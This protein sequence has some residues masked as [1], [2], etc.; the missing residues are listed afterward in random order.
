MNRRTFMSIAAGALI[1]LS[2]TA[3]AQAATSWHYLGTRKVNP[4]VDQDR[5]H[6]GAVRGKFR[7]IRLTVNGNGLYVYNLRVIY[8]NGAIDNIPVRFHFA[9][10]TWSR[11]ID[12]RGNRRFIKEIRFFYGRPVNGKGRTYVSVFGRR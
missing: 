7:K 5:I 11:V 3:T 2:L 9:Q 10:G 4:I 8:V 6:V 12:L 1:G